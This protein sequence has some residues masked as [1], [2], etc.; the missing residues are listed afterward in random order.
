LS[1]EAAS[2]FGAKLNVSVENIAILQSNYLI[3]SSK[4]EFAPANGFVQKYTLAVTQQN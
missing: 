4:E 1:K 2:K 3:S